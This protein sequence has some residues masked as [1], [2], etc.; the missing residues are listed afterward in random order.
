MPAPSQIKLYNLADEY[1][2]SLPVPARWRLQSAALKLDFVTSSAL[3]AK[4]SQLRI[5]VN[6]VTIAQWQPDPHKLRR[7]ETVSIPLE[8]LLA[9]YNELRFLAAQHYTEDQCEANTSPELWTEINPATSSVKFEYALAPLP[10]SLA[11]LTEVFDPK[12]PEANIAL[13]FPSLNLSEQELIAGSLIAQGIGL[14]LKYAPFTLTLV[15]AV[16]QPNRALRLALPKDQDAVLIGTNEQLKALLAPEILS[17]INGPYLG[18]FA[19]PEAPTVLLVVS[20]RTPDEVRQAALAF[21]LMNFPLPDAPETVIAQGDFE[22]LW[23]HRTLPMLQPNRTYTLAQLG[24]ATT[25]RRGLTPDPIEFEFYLPPDAFAPENAEAVFLLH[26]AYNAGM[27]QDS[28][29]EMRINGVFERAIPLSEAN[30]A[31]YRDWRIQVPLRS[32]HPG[33]NL[34][35]FHPLLVPAVSGKCL[36]FQTDQLKIALYQ[37]S[38]LSLPPFSHYAELPDLA[39]FARTG[40]P[41]VDSGDGSGVGLYLLNRS[42]D[43]ILSAWQLL[44]QLARLNG[45]PLAKIRFGFDAPAEPL[46]LLA[47]GGTVKALPDLF[48]N[49]PLKLNQPFNT[50]LYPAGWQAPAPRPWWQAFLPPA[51]DPLFVQLVTMTQSGGLGGLAAGMSFPH[52]TFPTKLVTA[53]IAQDLLYPAIRSLTSPE[54]WSQ[55]QGDLIIWQP[56]VKNLFW[57]RVGESFYRG[58]ATPSLRLI[59]H[60][61]RHPWQWLAAALAVCLALA[62]W[63]RR[64]LKRY[65]LRHHP[66]AKEIA[67]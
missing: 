63:I 9:G 3:V 29:L 32:F 5:Q 8:L 49:A 27:R 12:S 25:S 23:P 34:I 7:I 20:G 15:Q 64:Y 47:V 60:F 66:D 28:L 55:M 18:L 50:L 11:R 43:T 45:L 13:M 44:A 42:P 26:F 41:Y 67:P 51:P 61:A 24:F 48:Q 56:E 30:G 10:L 33:R 22:A 16:S 58:Q 54:L 38:R 62:W 40:F 19:N 57:Q 1:T 2:L 36:L 52:P 21:A 14:R 59:F 37:D 31:H 17:H 53:F 6:G 35:S 39:L 46:D 4:R 65:K